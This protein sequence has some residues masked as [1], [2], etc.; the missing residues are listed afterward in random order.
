MPGPELRPVEKRCKSAP[1]S[2]SAEAPWAR[3]HVGGFER[4]YQKPHTLPGDGG[5]RSTVSMCESLNTHT[6]I[7]HAR[8]RINIYA[9]RKDKS[10]YL[11]HL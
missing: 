2:H 5:R 9:I 1:A 11:Y 8:I 4:I 3:N 6:Q 7:T 10:S